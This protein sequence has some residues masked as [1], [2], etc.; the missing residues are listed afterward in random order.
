MTRSCGTESGLSSEKT[1]QRCKGPGPLAP[2]VIN[3]FSAARIGDF[4][5]HLGLV[6]LDRFENR[7]EIDTRRFE[8]GVDD[9]TRTRK[10]AS[11]GEQRR[12]S[13]RRR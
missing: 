5:R 12:R 9:I 3:D 8:S 4:D 2:S 7:Y 11:R 1:T 10:A 13:P 6:G